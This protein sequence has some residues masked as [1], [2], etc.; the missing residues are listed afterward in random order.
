MENEKTDP[1]TPVL[2]PE[3]LAKAVEPIILPATAPSA[4]DIVAA[5]AAKAAD[6][7]EPLR[8]FNVPNV[9]KTKLAHISHVE[10]TDGFVVVYT[11]D[12]KVHRKT[13]EEVR[14]VA[15]DCGAMLE[16]MNK[17]E[18]KGVPVTPHIKAQTQELITK[19]VAASRKAK[20][21][22]ETALKMDH[23]SRA[24]KRMSDNLAW[25][26]GKLPERGAYTA[27]NLPE[28]ANIK[29]LSIRFPKISEG[30]IATI[31]RATQVPYNVRLQILSG[32]NGKRLMEENKLTAQ[33]VMRMTGAGRI[34][35]PA[36]VGIGKPR[37]TEAKVTVP[38]Q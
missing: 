21:Q 17:S 24:V 33:D 25:Q 28:E 29:H 5:A 32:M 4:I 20:Y 23:A 18:A 22:Q 36:G 1:L 8:V 3:T 37:G 26:K 6:K 12:G 9:F 15:R 16:A 13:A 10:A 38:R 2:T 7:P 35:L 27:D 14:E 11:N 34:E 31:M 19:L 30:D